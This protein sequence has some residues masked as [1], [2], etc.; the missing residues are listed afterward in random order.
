METQDILKAKIGTKENAKLKPAKVKIL[1]VEIQTKTKEGNV[2]KSPLLHILCQ[3]PDRQDALKLSKVKFERNG[4][5]EAVSLWVN[6]EDGEF[7]KSS[8]VSELLRFLKVD[9]LENVAGKEI[10]AIE[11]SKEDTYLCLKAY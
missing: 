2:M 8:A 4:K 7:P 3:H 5:L 11:Q 10:E 1:G 9:S 6:L